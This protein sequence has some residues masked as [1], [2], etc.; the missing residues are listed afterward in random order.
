MASNHTAHIVELTLAL[1]EP[2]S[3]PCHDFI[4]KWNRLKWRLH[5][6]PETSKS[7]SQHH[8]QSLVGAN[9][10]L[11]FVSEQSG[12]F[13]IEVTWQSFKEIYMSWYRNLIFFIS[14]FWILNRMLKIPKKTLGF[15]LLGM[16]WLHFVIICTFAF[17]LKALICFLM[18]LKMQYLVKMC[19]RQHLMPKMIDVI[20]E[21][22]VGRYLKCGLNNLANIQ[23]NKIIKILEN[24]TSWESCFVSWKL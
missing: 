15:R 19:L 17:Y 23:S 18:L 2:Q 10:V 14:S 1:A 5:T 20:S 13:Q 4:S 21:F 12:F 8:R 11:F 16:E 6:V 9:K 24:Y 3:K 7:W 22:F